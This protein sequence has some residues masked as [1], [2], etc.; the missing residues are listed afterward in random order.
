MAPSRHR[1]AKLVAVEQHQGRAIQ[2]EIRTIGL[3]LAKL[4]FQI[5]GV[6]EAATSS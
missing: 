2:M 4:V 6:N 5:H 1:H 3:D